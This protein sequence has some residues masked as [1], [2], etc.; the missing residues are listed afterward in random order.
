VI[1]VATSALGKAGRVSIGGI[2]RDTER[3]NPDEVIARYSSTIGLRNDQK[4]T[5]EIWKQ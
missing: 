3:N 5:Q 4:H 2:V 1:L